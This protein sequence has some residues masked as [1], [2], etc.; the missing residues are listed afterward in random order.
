MED[1]IMKDNTFYSFIDSNIVKLLIDSPNPKLKNKYLEK[2]I[3][4]HDNINLYR[5]I[6]NH[7][8]GLYPWIKVLSRCD[9]SEDEVK[10]YAIEQTITANEAL[11]DGSFRT[12]YYKVYYM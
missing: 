4:I 12:V 3:I 5:K 9:C 8:S 7:M 6:R 1:L 10:Q 11:D 2:L